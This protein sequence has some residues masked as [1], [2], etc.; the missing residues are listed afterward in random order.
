MHRAHQLLRG[1][2]FKVLLLASH[3]RQASKLTVQN[4]KMAQNWLTEM[5]LMSMKSSMLLTMANGIIRRLT[6]STYT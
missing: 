3:G 5:D 1:P 2:L 4:G 6:Y